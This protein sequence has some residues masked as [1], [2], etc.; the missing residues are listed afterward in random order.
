MFIF[1]RKAGKTLQTLMLQG[2]AQQVAFP[3]I[4]CPNG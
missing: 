3:H 4:P 1:A 2:F